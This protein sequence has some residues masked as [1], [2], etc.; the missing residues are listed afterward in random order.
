MRTLVLITLFLFCLNITAQKKQ[1]IKGNKEVVEVYNNL[2]PFTKLEVMD[3]LE[4]TL[5]QTQYEGYRLKTDSNLV[6]VIKFEIIDGTLKIYTTKRIVSD[7]K[8]EIYLTFNSLEK[9]TLGKNSKLKGQ[10]NLRISTLELTCA[11]ESVFDLDIQSDEFS[12]LMNGNANGRLKLNTIS[13]TMILNDNAY[14]KGS[15]SAEDFDLTLNKRADM[16]IEGST[17]ELNLI[18]SGSSDV[19]AKKLKVTRATINASNTSDIYVYASK[20]L[21]IYAKGK[22]FIYV[23]GN[24][25]IE[26]EGLNDKSQIIKK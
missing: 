11:D 14:L 13:S 25:E 23:Y 4:I 3:E 22:S 6:D 9:I 15:I 21:S 20:K 8:L 1:K 12:V 7:K 26:V 16:N 10:N 18:A 19:K 2:E 5:M 24:P 17:D